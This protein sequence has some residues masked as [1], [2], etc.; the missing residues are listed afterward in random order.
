MALPTFESFTSPISN[1][2]FNKNAITDRIGLDPYYTGTP[3]ILYTRII[4]FATWILGVIAIIILIYGGLL[5]IT[6]GGEAEKAE[7]GKKTII[8]ALIGLIV[9][10]VSY[11]VY[12]SSIGVLESSNTNGNLTDQQLRQQLN[13]PPEEVPKNQG[14]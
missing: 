10:I 2:A 11:T 3:D 7:R 8:G 4:Y 14:P 13:T 1:S 5:Y 12:N 6:A 9:I